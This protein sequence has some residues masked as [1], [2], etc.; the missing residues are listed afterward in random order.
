MTETWKPIP[1][2]DGFEA[3]DAGNVRSV[4]RFIGLRPLTGKVLAQRKSNRGY[5]LVDVNGKT[6]TV[7]RLVLL[8]HIG[9][10][11]DGSV[12]R[13]LNDN[14]Q[15]N[16]LVNLV[17][18]TQS[19]NEQ[20]K[21]RNGSRKPAAPKPVRHCKGCGTVLT[22]NG[23][24]CHPCRV[25]LGTDA[26]VAMWGGETLEDAAQRLDY[27]AVHLHKLAVEFG[28]YGQSP[29]RWRLGR[30]LRGGHRP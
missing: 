15:D 22:T 28:G 16:R 20:D 3:S 13:H 19:E 4:D 9:P 2:Y 27:P 8:S 10:A 17:W 5:Q 18:G 25:Q 14:P 6:F 21:I 24:R 12:A 30:A 1:G 26:T 11:P 7:H 23:W 29:L